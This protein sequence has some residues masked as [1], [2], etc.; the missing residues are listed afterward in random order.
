MDKFRLPRGEKYVP[1]KPPQQ[2]L[3]E[4]LAKD[5]NEINNFPKDM[6]RN[7]PIP[8]RHLK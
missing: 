6:R 4:H 5:P 2:Y 7:E 8:K 1:P 3:L